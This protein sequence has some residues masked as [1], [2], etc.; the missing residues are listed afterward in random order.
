MSHML[1]IYSY[2]ASW[3][4][5]CLIGIQP[6]LLET[7]HVIKG[8]LNFYTHVPLLIVAPQRPPGNKP[9]PYKGH[10][11]IAENLKGC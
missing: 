8:H 4:V 1:R 6:S 3:T 2:A 9:P 10:T 5:R 11:V 7:V